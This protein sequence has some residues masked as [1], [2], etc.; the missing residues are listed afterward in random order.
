[1]SL[2]KDPTRWY[3]IHCKPRQEERA[4]E[5]LERQGFECFRPLRRVEKLRMDH[6]REILE[7]LFPRY[8]FIRLSIESNWH[9]VGS[10]LGVNRIVRFGE[11]PLPVADE[12]IEYI[13]RRI[14]SESVKEPYLKPGERVLV[15]EGCFSQ[16]EAIF[17]AGDGDERVML[18]MNILH[19]EQTLSFPV[20]SV[21]KL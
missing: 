18:L 8:L 4:R 14:E 16:V 12:I 2:P 13:R 7:S 21:K 11:Y 20:T 5:N 10:T 6:R 9:P 1:M 17:V 19:S 3:L 15:T